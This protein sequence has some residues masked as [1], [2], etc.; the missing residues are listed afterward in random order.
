MKYNFAKRQYIKRYIFNK[1]ILN[2]RYKCVD[3]V[4]PVQ[5]ILSLG[6]PNGHT[7]VFCQ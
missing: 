2:I 6:T 7:V 1:N 5:L 3:S 4:D